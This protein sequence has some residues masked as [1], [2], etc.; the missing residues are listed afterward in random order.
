MNDYHKHPSIPHLP[1]SGKTTPDDDVLTSIEHFNGQDIV[2]T[3][4]MDG[5]QTSMYND[6]IHAR[7]VDCRPHI[8]QTWVKNLYGQIR[9]EI[10][11]N[12]RICGENTY[13]KHNIHYSNLESY[14]YLFAVWNEENVCLE[15]EETEEWA[16]LLGLKIV[17]ILYRGKW[18]PEVV[19]HLYTP[20]YNDDDCEGYVVRLASKFKYQDFFYSIAK[21]VSPYFRA[22]L[23]N[24]DDNWRTRAVIPNNLKKI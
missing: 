14:F 20:K 2:V 1:W 18:D 6:Y 7:A 24:S 11:D 23:K 9:H 10:P 17:P 3:V 13:A 16:K 5:E 4:K 12:W 22:A 19:E 15:W 21:Y 8:S